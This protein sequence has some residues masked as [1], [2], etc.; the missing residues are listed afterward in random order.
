M[1]ETIRRDLLKLIIDLLYEIPTFGS[2]SGFCYDSLAMRQLEQ[3]DWLIKDFADE[4]HF[5]AIE[6]S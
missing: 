5:T 1:I 6:L 2:P 4:S 3:P